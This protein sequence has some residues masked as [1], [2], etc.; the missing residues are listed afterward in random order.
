MEYTHGKLNGI[1][2]NRRFEHP[3]SLNKE[4]GMHTHRILYATH[5][6]TD[7][8]DL[9]RLLKKEGIP[10]ALTHAANLREAR[11]K[12]DEF[13]FDLIITDYCM[14]DGT[15][16]KLCR[17]LRT[18]DDATPV[19]FYSALSRNIDIKQAREAGC[20]E[21]LV[22]P[23][24]RSDVVPMICRYLEIGPIRDVGNSRKQFGTRFEPHLRIARP[25][26]S[27]DAVSKISK[28]LAPVAT[29][30]A[31]AIFL[32]FAA[33]MLAK[34]ARVNKR[35][36]ANDAAKWAATMTIDQSFAEAELVN[37]SEPRFT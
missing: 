15:G 3:W 8:D 12:L 2:L 14:E 27:A 22:Q 21:Y 36:P 11:Q 7:A 35:S 4:A 23:D 32:S 6:G 28:T 29:F 34:A 25:R 37:G 24:D 13:R 30:T 19:I 18:Y 33:G 26:R 1:S 20:N 5:D 16:V 10:I 31:A 17:E 9:G